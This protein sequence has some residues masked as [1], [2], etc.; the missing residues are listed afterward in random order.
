M[1]KKLIQLDNDNDNN[2][3]YQLCERGGGGGDGGRRRWW[4][5]L[6]SNNL[7]QTNGEGR[8]RKKLQIKTINIDNR[9]IEGLVITIILLIHLK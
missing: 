2:D 7:T 4:W 8:N 6:M 3:D 9:K 1:E 5:I